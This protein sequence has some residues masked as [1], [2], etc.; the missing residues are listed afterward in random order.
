MAGLTTLLLLLAL[1]PAAQAATPEIE[2][3][4]EEARPGRV[5]QIAGSGFFECLAPI[6]E[7]ED[8]D[9]ETS[10]PPTE[11]PPPAVVEVRFDGRAPVVPAL[12][13]TGSF[14]VEI[15]VPDVAPGSYLVTASCAAGTGPPRQISARAVLRVPTVQPPT[16]SVIVPPVTSVVTLPPDTSVIVVPTPPP[17]T[18]IPTS[19]P[20]IEPVGY[21]GFVSGVVVVLI[22]L[23]VLGVLL[24]RAARSRSRP[25]RSPGLPVLDA[26]PA[27]GPTGS[28]ELRRI[29]PDRGLAL[30]VVPHSDP[31]VQVLRRIGR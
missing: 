20:P 30:R 8:T 3:S 15:T 21:D 22:V 2:L 7:S 13:D 24:I 18:S 10:V 25:D 5:V 19:A 14:L 17:A 11:P 31:G 6:I 16:T 4:P 27:Q 26:I 12:E 28:L 29:G 1:V 23:V 9:P